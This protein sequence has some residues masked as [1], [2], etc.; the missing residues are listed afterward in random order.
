MP[1]LTVVPLA[2]SHA[3]SCWGH[4]QDPAIYEYIPGCPPPDVESLERDF[5]RLT[6]GCPRP[7]ELWLNWTA[8][9]DGQPVA[10][11]QATVYP[12]VATIGYTVFPAYWRQGIGAAGARWL[13]AELF[14]QH[15]VSLVHAFIDRRNCGSLRLIEQLGFHALAVHEQPFDTP[16]TD[17][18][19]ALSRAAW[20]AQHAVC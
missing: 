11:L 19:W 15:G 8:L 2:R 18:V 20:S 10:M 13:L 1:H 5:E 17:D 16:S 9:L 6:A 3:A 7:D 14:T 12:D 4:L